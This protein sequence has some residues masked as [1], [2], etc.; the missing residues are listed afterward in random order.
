MLSTTIPLV[1]ALA[2]SVWEAAVGNVNGPPVGNANDITH[3][4][5]PQPAWLPLPVT[6][7]NIKSELAPE[8]IS[9]AGEHEGTCCPS[10]GT[11]VFVKMIGV[12][13]SVVLFI[14]GPVKLI[15]NSARF[16]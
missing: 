9:V 14:V 1:P 16:W 11:T 13:A 2:A 5:P 10:N 15:R 12:P 4:F 3:P 8:L 7:R 6:L